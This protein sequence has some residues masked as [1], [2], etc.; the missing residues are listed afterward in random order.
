MRGWRAENM[1]P[2]SF[3]RRCHSWSS[4]RRFHR[5]KTPLHNVGV[6]RAG[7]GRGAP[8]SE[9]C[10]DFAQIPHDASW[11]E[12]ETSRELA[13]SLHLIDGAVGERHDVSKLLPADCFRRCAF[14]FPSHVNLHRS[15][16]V[17]IEINSCGLLEAP[18]VAWSA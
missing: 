10:L 12:R 9:P 14:S 2:C 18:S 11:R 4:T 16:N 15:F 13:A 3:R 5:P 17:F 6:L 1:S 7:N 8:R